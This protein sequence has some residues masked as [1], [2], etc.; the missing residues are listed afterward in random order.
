MT[1]KTKT[2]AQLS[3]GEETILQAIRRW[4][5][6]AV[7]LADVKIVGCERI[8]LGG[9][10]RAF[11][12]LLREADPYVV[13]VNRTTDPSITLFELQ[14]LYILSECR[15]GNSETTTELLDWWFPA[16]LVANARVLLE[17]LAST[18]DTLALAFNSSAWIRDHLLT[19]T[20]KRIKQ[21]N[22][23]ERGGAATRFGFWSER[24]VTFH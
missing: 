11:M 21:T 4:R 19:V 20:N 8:C 12:D 18:I 6:S 23:S 16:G 14:L 9:A 17:D 1:E 13:R 24:T 15:E 22:G 7:D 5:Y 10:L 3:E 2:R